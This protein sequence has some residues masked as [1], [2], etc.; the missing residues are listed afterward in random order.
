MD[1]S[2]ILFAF[3]S[4]CLFNCSCGG[5][6]PPLEVILYR[7]FEVLLFRC[8]FIFVWHLFRWWCRLVRQF[9]FLGTN[10]LL[11][12]FRSLIGFDLG[13]ALDRLRRSRVVGGYLGVL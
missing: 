12:L 2:F 10:W 6:L 1:L 9:L 11:L 5:V 3:S 4:C 7:Y 13:V 8:I